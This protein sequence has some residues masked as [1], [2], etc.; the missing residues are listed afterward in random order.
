VRER[1]RGGREELG[2]VLFLEREGWR[3][4]GGERTAGHGH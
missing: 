3:G 4:R 1:A 2:L